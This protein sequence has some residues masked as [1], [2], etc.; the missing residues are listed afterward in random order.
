MQFYSV[1]S[2]AKAKTLSG[3]PQILESFYVINAPQSIEAW[4]F[5]FLL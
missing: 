4:V 5:I 2:T 3:V 1:V